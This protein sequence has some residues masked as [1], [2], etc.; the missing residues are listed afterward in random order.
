MK[1]GIFLLMLASDPSDAKLRS[2]Y[3]SLDPLSVSQHLAY[4]DLYSKSEWGQKAL[5]DACRLLA[6]KEVQK[7]FFPNENALTSLISLINKSTDQEMPNLDSSSISHIDN[8]A[9]RL[10]H[11]SLKGH[12]VWTE[13]AL[14][15]LP[16]TEI[17]LARGLFITQFGED[18]QK[19]QTY[20]SFIDLMALQILARL[21]PQ[22]TPEE[23]IIAINTFI[24]DEMGFRFPPHS[25]YAKNIDQYTFLP[26]VIDSRR[27]VCLGVSIL[28]LCIAQRL[29]LPLEMITP[30][31]HI[32]VRYRSNDKIIN[33][34]TTARGVHIDCEE[35]LSVNTRSL[36]S[37]TIREVIGMAHFN[38]ASIFW[39]NGDYP[40]ALEAYQK[41]EPYM[42]NDPVLKE[43]MGY[44][45]LLTGHTEHGEKNLKEIK[46]YIPPHAIT[47]NHMA[48]DYFL[49]NI[50]AEGISLIFTK[51]EEDRASVLAKKSQLEI[52]LKKHPRFR[53]GLLSLAMCWVELHRMGEALEILNSFQTLEAND[54]EVHYYLAILHAQ[55]HNFPKAWQHLHQAETIVNSHQYEPKILKDL[56]R[57]LLQHCPE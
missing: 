15:N 55:R 38:Q 3:N 34:E 56:R 40:K 6:G 45:L 39:Q 30:P 21:S 2:L 57:E 36:Q 54:P 4:Y 7:V 52:L 9:K 16:L 26:S 37:R 13:E 10:H 50:D 35:Y 22:A 47:K 32:Y 53:A 12:T 8:L 46:D 23:K 44:I 51:N 43:L 41:A 17:D 27:G 25:L 5:D 31:G 20:E 14:L 19:I 29:N 24:F 42:K 49:G 28:Y 33:I 11:Q 48:E 1:M 18:Q